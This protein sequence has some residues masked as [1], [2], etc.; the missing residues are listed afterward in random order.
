MRSDIIKFY[1]FNLY[2][3][4]YSVGCMYGCYILGGRDDA[5]A[6]T[7]GSEWD[8]DESAASSDDSDGYI[9]ISCSTEIN[10]CRALYCTFA[11]L[12]GRVLF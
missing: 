6:A 4:G 11:I 7:S 3:I 12:S 2:A 8:S 10:Y 1:V 9:T 5:S